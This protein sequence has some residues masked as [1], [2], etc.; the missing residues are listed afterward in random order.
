MVRPIDILDRYWNFKGFRPMQEEIIDT[1]IDGKD[2]F[3]LLPTGGGKSLC[4]Q[5]PAMISDGICLVI[6]PLIALMKDQVKALKTIGIKAIA[7]TSDL[8]PDEIDTELDNCIFGAYKFLYISPER[9]QQELVQS[10]IKQMRVNLIAVDEAH[11]ISQWGHDFRPAYRDINILR[12]F[13]PE[14]NLIALTATAKPEVVEDIITHLYLEDAKHF[15][16]SF[17]R[18]ELAL[19]VIEEEDKHYRL[20][21]LLKEHKGSSIVYVRNRKSTVTISEYLNT[22]GINAVHYHGGLQHEEKQSHYELWMSGESQVIVATNAFGMGIDKADVETVIH[23]NLP[24][25]LESYYQEAGRAGRNGKRAFGIILKNNSDESRLRNQFLKVLPDVK[26]VKHI[27]RKLCSYFQVAYGERPENLFDFKF[28]QFCKQYDLNS[29]K[30]YN[31]IL[32]LDRNGIIALGHN[33]KNQTTFQLKIGKEQLFSYMRTHPM[34]AEMLKVILRTY[35]GVFD[36]P[37]RINLLLIS[38]KC[39]QT[40]EQIISGLKRLEQ[41]EIIA[42]RLSQTDAEIAFLVPREDDKTIN[43]ISRIIEQQ[44][45]L[46]HEQIR[47]VLDYVENDQI[48]RSRQILAYFGEKSGEDCGICSVCMRAK[49]PESSINT[50]EIITRIIAVLKEGPLNSRELMKHTR[51]SEKKVSELIR[52]M[53]EKNLIEVTKTNTYKP[54]DK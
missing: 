6:S 34:I 19:M 22:I 8:R 9:L 20:E 40:E 37:T 26:F 42:L 2:V 41:D 1:V 46:K 31:A 12:E 7:L 44:N 21:Q 10:R 39:E 28:D 27:Y 45:K 18:E 36:V 16:R 52:H 4:Y 5:V 30:A 29:A 49:Q 25:S 35:G 33:F 17:R 43:S 53:L 3:A 48:C 32:L 11:C 38:E 24:E 51:L 13:H 54:V 50:K 23:I 15:Q 47:S 14:V